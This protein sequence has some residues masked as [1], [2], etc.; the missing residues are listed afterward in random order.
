MAPASASNSSSSSGAR[1]ASASRWRATVASSPRA[2]GP[3]RARCGAGGGPVLDG[4]ANERHQR[5]TRDA[6]AGGDALGGVLERDE[7]VR[8]DR[9]RGSGR[10]HGPRRRARRPAC[11]GHAR[12]P[13]RAPARAASS[14][15]PRSRRRRSVAP[16]GVTVISGCSARHSRSP[17]DVEPGRAGAVADDRAVGDRRA[18]RPRSRRPARRAA[19][20]PRPRRRIRAREGRRRRG[21]RH[22]APRR[23]RCRAGRCRRLRCVVSSRSS[24]LGDTGR[25]VRVL[26]CSS[27]SVPRR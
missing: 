6:G 23:A 5:L 27:R 7:E 24:S 11:R 16:S 26:W 13:R 22:A 4:R 17:S 2:I 15:R 10:R 3:V 8:G 12:A 1:S 19:R 18:R 20:R 25:V 14:R 21:P 9:G